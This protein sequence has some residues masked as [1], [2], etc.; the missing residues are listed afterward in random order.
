M[1]SR[2]RDTLTFL[3]PRK[4]HLSHGPRTASLAFRARPFCLSHFSRFSFI[5]N[6]SKATLQHAITDPR[7]FR[8]SFSLQFSIGHFSSGKSHERADH[9][10]LGG[11]HPSSVGGE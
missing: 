3:A 9:H 2:R 7:K 11:L 5:F 4:G 10:N 6:F 1:R 8:D